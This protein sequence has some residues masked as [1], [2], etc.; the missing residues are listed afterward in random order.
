MPLLSDLSDRSSWVEPDDVPRVVVTYGFASDDLAGFEVE[1]HQ[2]IKGQVLFVQRGGLICEV[3]GGMWMVPPSSAVWIP[4]GAQ[5]LIKVTGALEGYGAFIVPEVAA[6]LPLTT[7]AISV[8]PLLRELLIRS[9]RLPL[10]YDDRGA[11]MHMTAVLLNELATAKVENLHLPMP[12]DLRLR[13][14]IQMMIDTPEN[15][16]TVE[17]WAEKAGMSCRSLERLV[18]RQTGMSLGRWRQQLRIVLAVKWLAG[19]ATIQQVAND[20]GYADTPSFITMFRKAL[21]RS[22]GRYITERHLRR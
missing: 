3:D 19:G 16:G 10:L 17:T 11:N 9:A 20:L 1:P 8:T 15:R 14:I 13:R 22:P 18:R 5:H 6:K 7:C 2:H 12:T 4:G 21:G